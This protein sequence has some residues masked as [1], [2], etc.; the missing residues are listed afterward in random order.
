MMMKL[1]MIMLMMIMMMMIMII[2][3]IINIMTMM[4]LI[5]IMIIYV[6]DEHHDVD[7]NHDDH[8]LEDS[9]A[10]VNAYDKFDDDNEHGNCDDMYDDYVDD[11]EDDVDDNDEGDDSEDGGHDDGHDQGGDDFADEGD[12]HDG[13]DEDVDRVDHHDD[14]HDDDH[15]NGDD[16]D[17]DVDGDDY[18]ALLHPCHK[19][20]YG[21]PPGFTEG[22]PWITERRRSAFAA[23]FPGPK[24]GSKQGS[25]WRRSRLSPTVGDK[26]ECRFSGPLFSHVFVFRFGRSSGQF[27]TAMGGLTF[28]CMPLTCCPLHGPNPTDMIFTL[29]SHFPPRRFPQYGPSPP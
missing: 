10:D 28:R 6:D 19:K 13:G 9:D 23:G 14:G 12:I 27:R 1:M 5:I 17:E 25:I 22:P 16:E 4:M 20:T 3:I 21:A 15:A 7:D 29:W 8:Y 11:D 18:S 2:M 26:L 24:T